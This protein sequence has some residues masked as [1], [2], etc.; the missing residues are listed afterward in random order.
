M[1]ESWTNRCMNTIIQLLLPVD[2]PNNNNIIIDLVVVVVMMALSVL[3][4]IILIRV[5]I[6][7]IKSCDKFAFS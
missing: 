2:W 6:V 3:S 7:I 4:I 1:D 5:I